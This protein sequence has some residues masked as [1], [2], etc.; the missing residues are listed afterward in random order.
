MTFTAHV[1][2]FRTWAAEYLA[3]VRTPSAEWECGYPDWRRLH[4][5]V[6]QFLRTRSW[7]SWTDG[8]RAD[9]LYVLARDNER[10]VVAA[11]LVEGL[12]A[13][14]L[15]A[16]VELSFEEGEEDARGQLADRLPELATL[17][18]AR[19]EELLVRLA[20]DP[21]ESVRSRALGALA[22]IRSSHA[23]RSGA[24]G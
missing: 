6:S 7:S 3:E 8:E 17:A 5:A 23:E 16:L 20:A 2:R 14:D 13:E 24:E 12:P 22:R 19:V 10:E 11:V 1:M 4:D 9:V 21:G 15:F 18:P